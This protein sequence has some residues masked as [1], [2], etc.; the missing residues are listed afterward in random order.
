MSVLLNNTA[1]AATTPSFATA[2]T[3]A[4]G[5]GAGS[6]AV[7]DF[8]GDG[9]PDLVVTNLDDGTVSVLLNTTAAGATTPSFANRG[10]L[11]RRRRPPSRGGG[12]L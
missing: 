2:V 3:F 9:K 11:R 4:V 12:R 10:D 6:V 7:G 1:A 8:N 5:H